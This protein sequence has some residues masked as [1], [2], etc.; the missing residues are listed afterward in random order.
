MAENGEPRQ[1]YFEEALS[2]MVHDAASGGAI[3]HLVDMGYSVNQIMERLDYPTPKDRVE[4]TVFCYMTESG[5]LAKTLP[6]PEDAFH[7]I[8]LKAENRKQL[9]G[10]IRG[11]IT[12]NG[13]ANAY[14]CCACGKWCRIL[15]AMEKQDAAVSGLKDE[16]EIFKNLTSREKDYL[17]GIPWQR[18]VM[19]HRLTG[20]MLEIVMELALSGE[21]V[22]LYFLKDRKPFCVELCRP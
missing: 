6:V 16:A 13:E 2:N 17:L 18:E 7:R 1:R 20:R 9:S 10:I 21:P 4:D 11:Y 5:M 22:R 12:E 15:E 3:R 19:Y 8:T 14:V